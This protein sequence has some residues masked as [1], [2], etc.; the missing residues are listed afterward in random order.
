MPWWAWCCGVL[1]SGSRCSWQASRH[2]MIR[3]WSD[4]KRTRKAPNASGMRQPGSTAQGAG[5]GQPGQG[6]AGDDRAPVPPVR[7]ARHGV[8][9]V[10]AQRGG[11]PL[12]YADDGVSRDGAMGARVAQHVPPGA[13]SGAPGL[14]VR[15]ER[16]AEHVLAVLGRRGRGG[17]SSGD[18]D[19]GG[20]E[21][22]R[23]RREEPPPAEG[24]GQW[25]TLRGP[26]SPASPAPRRCSGS[27][28]PAYGNCSPR[29]AGRRTPNRVAWLE[30]VKRADLAALFP[31]KFSIPG[32]PEKVSAAEAA[33]IAVARM[34]ARRP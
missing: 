31:G 15:E 6:A 2:K 13:V 20:Q 1:A 34:E 14:R 22:R 27:R 11:R 4:G 3:R 28:K 32:E 26:T 18:A 16:G 19:A 24:R 21:R 25:L 8:S 10:S 30:F 33:A 29:R 5:G 12:Q 7:I 23:V 9:G 17:R